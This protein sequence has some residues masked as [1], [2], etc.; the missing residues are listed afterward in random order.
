[1]NEVNLKQ[2]LC[3]KYECELD[4]LHLVFCIVEFLTPNEIM[5]LQN[6]SQK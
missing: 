4:D 2:I 5:F 3:E 1:M 6:N